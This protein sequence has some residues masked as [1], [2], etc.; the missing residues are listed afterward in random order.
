MRPCPRPAVSV[1]ADRRWTLGV[2][3]V[4]ERADIAAWSGPPGCQL[5]LALRAAKRV[6]RAN[7]SAGVT[8]GMEQ[9]PLADQEKVAGLLTVDAG[10]F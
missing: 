9:E 7:P 10:Y 1:G 3:A 5:A 6:G 4:G 2:P 8:V